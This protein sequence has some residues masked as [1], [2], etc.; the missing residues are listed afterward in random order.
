MVDW[1]EYAIARHGAQ[2]RAKAA[3]GPLEKAEQYTSDVCES[4]ISELEVR[5]SQRPADV[6]PRR[7]SQWDK[8]T[9]PL[10]KSA[11]RP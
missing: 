9:R 2:L 6:Q 3:E 10:V 4:V 7:R 11:H 5:E 1:I 8:R